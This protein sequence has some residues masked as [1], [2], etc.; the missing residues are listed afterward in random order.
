M[1]AVSP[2]S[3]EELDEE[4]DDEL[5][6]DEEDEELLLDEDVPDS[7]SFLAAR[8]AT[9]CARSGRCSLRTCSHLTDILGRPLH[10]CFQT[11]SIQQQH[12][13]AL[14][15]CSHVS[16]APKFSEFG[17]VHPRECHI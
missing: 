13:D 5:L 4:A 14:Q 9:T 11:C 6:L 10:V 1:A 17:H 12:L 8:S 3:L 16:T 7:S 15:V 2:S